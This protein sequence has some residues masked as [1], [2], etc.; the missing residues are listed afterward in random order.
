M[1]ILETIKKFIPHR[2][3]N[4]IHY[5]RFLGSFNFFRILSWNFFHPNR[6]INRILWNTFFT[7]PNT[8][9]KK[10]SKKT[11]KENL[12]NSFN[13]FIKNGGAILKNYFPTN[14]IDNFLHEYKNIIEEEKKLIKPEK[15][16]VSEHK[17][18]YVPISQPLIDLWLDDS[19]IEFIKSSLGS[20][21]YAR[22]YPRLIYT[23]Y[24]LDESLTTK[25]YYSGKFENKKVNGPY[26]WHVDHAAGH[27]NLHVLLHD[28]N[29]ENTHMQFL[30]GSN[31]YFNSRNLYSDEVIDRFKNK[32]LDCVGGKGSV[33]FHQ[34]NT[35]HKVVGKKNSERLNLIFSFSKGARIE[36]DCNRIAKAFSGDFNVENL[37]KEKRE[38]LKGIFPLSTVN[39]LIKNDLR[40][41][42]L[43]EDT[44][45]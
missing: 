22:E 39:N 12:I 17:I 37:S 27:V 5:G 15:E 1:N 9:I 26:F 41:P 36:M 32:P 34:G 6:I 44:A 3:I 23:K 31:K 7:F 20:K 13:F 42:R 28:T 8:K 19:L 29:I 25:D 40:K 35:L 33:Y 4:E 30:P 11:N 43:S 45:H 21:I 18:M 16:N 24:L 14:K 38:I 2:Q 10:Y